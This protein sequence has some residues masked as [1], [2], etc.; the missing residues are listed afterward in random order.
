[1]T[2]GGHFFEDFNIGQEFKHPLGRTVLDA[3]NVWMTLLT[4]NN[5][6]LHFDLVYAKSQGYDSLL[7][8]STFTLALITGLSV[9]DLS[10]NGINLGWENVRLTKPVFAGD[11]L[12][13]QSTIV[14]VRQS[15]T[16]PDM[17]IVGAE[18][19]GLNQRGEIV[20][21]FRRNFMVRCRGTVSSAEK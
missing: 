3:D 6:P 13:A 21:S 4:V 19:R 5:N 18:T 9:N 1:M 2:E 8:D 14:I 12:H 7:V 10:R 16:H 15:K 17:G 11:T 20:I